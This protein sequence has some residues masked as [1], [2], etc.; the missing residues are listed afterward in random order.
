[1]GHLVKEYLHSNTHK[2]IVQ[3]YMHTNM[4]YWFSGQ[5]CGIVLMCLYG[6]LNAAAMCNTCAL[7]VI[8]IFIVHVMF[9]YM[10]T[11]P[12]CQ[13][14]FGKVTLIGRRKVD[15]V[16]EVYGV[17]LEEEERNGRLIQHSQGVLIVVIITVKGHSNL[18][19]N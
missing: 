19:N 18:R 13:N 4:C 14:K 5:E 12:L 3:S 2:F 11:L 8:M 7:T 17:N 10:Y 6:P 9:M 15:S 1:M 16:A